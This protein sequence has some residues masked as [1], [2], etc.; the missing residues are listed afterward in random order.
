MIVDLELGLESGYELLRFWHKN[1]R[2][3]AI[4]LVV[5]TVMGEHEREICGLFGV[6]W[7]ISKKDGLHALLSALSNIIEGNASGD[8]QQKA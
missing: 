1:P 8:M 4:P 6:N 2:L 7:F 3:R 5:W